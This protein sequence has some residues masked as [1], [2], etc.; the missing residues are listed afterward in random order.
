MG[1]LL[2]I[3][4]LL[5][6]LNSYAQAAEPTGS[7]SSTGKVRV[8]NGAERIAKNA[9][10]DRIQVGV[11]TLPFFDN[12]S[13]R[14]LI[15]EIWYPTDRQATTKPGEAF[16]LELPESRDA[17]FA[18]STVKKPLPLII[19]SHG[20]GGNRLNLSWLAHALVQKG[21]IVAAIDHY[22]S[23]WYLL[24]LPKITLQRWLRPRDISYGVRQLIRHSLF[25]DI[26]DP[27]KIGFVGF[28][29]GGLTGVW[30][31]GGIAN[32]YRKPSVTEPSL[33][34]LPD[35]I[36][37]ATIDSVDFSPAKES[38]R[39]PIIKAVFLMA[40]A[41]GFAF[42][43]VGLQSL[44][45]PVM[46]VAGAYDERV[47]I[48]ENALFFARSIPNSQIKI[49]PGK[50]GHFVFLNEASKIGKKQLPAYLIQDDTGVNRHK[51]HQEVSELAVQ[52]FNNNL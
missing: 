18:D 39:D 41:Y 48:K 10:K 21:Y 50:V 28:S 4:F 51:I 24:D 11:R 34:E 43:V 19:F 25:R 17:P 12:N 31:A 38:Y 1:L 14:P 20:D 35:N 5:G 30:L 46:I 22:E 7:V 26:I 6:S 47:P 42:N 16:W 52:F 27:N 40:P 44:S 32:Q 45:V 33:V 13:K 9:A 36:D 8:T 23:R 49:F 15:T 3:L 2:S 37:Q 29:L